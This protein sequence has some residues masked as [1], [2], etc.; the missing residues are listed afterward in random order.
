MSN[1]FQEEELPLVAVK[2]ILTVG[3]DGSYL[4]PVAYVFGSPLF[5]DFRNH[6]IQ[7]HG[8]GDI[9]ISATSIAGIA[10]AIAGGL[11]KADQTKNPVVHLHETVLI[12]LKALAQ[13]P[14]TLDTTAMVPEETKR[15]MVLD[16]VRESCQELPFLDLN[17][18]MERLERPELLHW[19]TDISWWA[20][21]NV[22]IAR[23]KLTN[24]SFQALSPMVWGLFKNAYSMH[25]SQWWFSCVGQQTRG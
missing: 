4:E 13:A 17:N 3:S 2:Y 22:S 21:L 23:S 12:Q 10:K 14:M 19:P 1:V 25:F 11:Q 18:F 24:D 20:L 8:K 15:S 6:T 16:F 5:V 9:R 7:L